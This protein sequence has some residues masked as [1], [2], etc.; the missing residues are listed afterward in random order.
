MIELSTKFKFHYVFIFKLYLLTYLKL[1]KFI[2]VHLNST[3]KSPQ[4]NYFM[5]VT[6]SW[7]Q[8]PNNILSGKT[9]VVYAWLTTPN[10][11]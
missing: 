9:R 7:I 2:Q 11:Y 1:F 6:Q 5:I 3:F 10:Y 8:T 4:I